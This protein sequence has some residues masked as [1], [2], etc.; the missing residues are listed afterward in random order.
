MP[1]IRKMKTKSG[2]SFYEI[3]VSRGRGKS[4]LPAD[5]I[6]RRAGAERPLNGSLQRSPQNLSAKATP[7]RL[8]AG[9]N[10]GKKKRRRPQK[11]LKS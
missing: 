1:S 10:N 6:P 9:K 11:P 2:Q 4:A 3:S 5:G 7:G 8:L